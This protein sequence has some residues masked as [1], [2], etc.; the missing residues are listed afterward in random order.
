[1][2]FE[3]QRIR[4]LVAILIPVLF[5]FGPCG[6]IAGGQLD[7]VVVTEKVKDFRFV[8]DV[9]QCALEV[10]NGDPHSVTVNCW[11]VGKQLYIGCKE[12][13][14][15]TWS[16]VITKNPNARVKIDGKLYPTLATRMQDPGAI[17]RAWRLSWEKYEEGEPEPVPEGYW[18]FHMRSQGKG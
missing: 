17:Q 4:A 5:G 9:E 2:I 10:K 8:Q 3:R 15:K 1:M 6:P 12:C 14:G 13:A 16:E 11:V 7:G 18:L